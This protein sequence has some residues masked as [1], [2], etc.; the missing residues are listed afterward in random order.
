MFGT[1]TQTLECEDCG[2]Q[3]TRKFPP[4]PVGT[5]ELKRAFRV[6]AGNG[7]L[8]CRFLGGPDDSETTDE[9]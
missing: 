4:C 8:K 7:C 3:W 5:I 9:G 1:I 2:H 6:P